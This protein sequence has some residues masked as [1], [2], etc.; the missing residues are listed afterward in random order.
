[1]ISVGE[2][3]INLHG[4]IEIGLGAP[5]VT[6]VVFGDSTV[7]I[8]PAI[9]SVKPGKDIELTDGIGIPSLGEGLPSPEHEHILVVLGMDCRRN[10][11]EKHQ[12]KQ[13]PFHV[14]LFYN[15]G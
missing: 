5:Y 14:D 7:E 13:K 9:G 4:R 1:M 8:D 15:K 12:G 2:D 10:A 3:R 6:E 11:Q